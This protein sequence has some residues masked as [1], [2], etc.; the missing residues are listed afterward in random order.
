MLDVVFNPL[1]S[2]RYSVFTSA[3][4]VPNKTITVTITI[5]FRFTDFGTDCMCTLMQCLGLLNQGELTM[6]DR[7][8]TNDVDNRQHEMAILPLR[9]E[10]QVREYDVSIIEIFSHGEPQ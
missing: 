7:F 5:L 3:L 1:C 8:K 6:N 9:P 4:S 10:I 2:V